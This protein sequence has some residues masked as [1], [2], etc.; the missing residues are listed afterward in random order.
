MAD[1]VRFALYTLEYNKDERDIVSVGWAE[2]TSRC[3]NKTTQ[4]DY[5]SS[6]MWYGLNK[7]RTEC[8][9]GNESD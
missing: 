9:Y 7:Q 5:T 8:I 2:D 3:G 4:K 6:F 1:N